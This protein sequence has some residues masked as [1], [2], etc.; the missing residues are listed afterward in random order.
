MSGSMK[1][2]MVV[3]PAKLATMVRDIFARAGMSEPHAALTADVLVWAELRGMGTHGVMRAPRY[4]DWIRKG[5]L[6]PRPSIKIVLET[7]GTA[8]VDCDGAA[9]PIA[10]MEGMRAACAKAREAGIGLGLV[11]QTTHTAA[12]GYYAQS[13]AREGFAAI[14]MAASSPLMA[15]HGARAAG[16]STAPL[17]IAVPGGDEPLALDMASSMISMGSLM[18]AKRTG[19]PI[20]EGTALSSEGKA[21]TDAREASIPLPLGGAKGSGLALM[22]EILCS[23]LVANPI[24]AEHLERTPRSR[25]H[26]QNGFV[27]AI[28]VERF[29]PLAVFR[30]EVQRLVD[31]LKR[32]PAAEGSEILMPGERGRRNAER[33]AQ[34]LSIPANV[35]EELA[36]L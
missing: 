22:A 29:V 36:A 19:T 23:L 27:I 1:P 31:A 13:A 28:D 9:G 12:L 21:T 20:P 25:R 30:N 8:V 35:Y 32:L 3:A 16:V 6:N 17:S 11:K 18:R 2:A 5:D 24:L 10:M 7:S 15:Y 26:Y 4:V 34:G 14:S 33:N